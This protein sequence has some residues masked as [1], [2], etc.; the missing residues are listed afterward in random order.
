SL[1]MKR[2][3]NTINVSKIIF[4]VLVFSF[5][6]IIIKLGFVAMAPTTD[7]IDLT[8]F[9]ENRNT[10]EEILKANRGSIYS[11]DGE[12]LAQSI[13]SYTVIAYLSETRT[14]NPE[15]P[16]HVVDK[17]RTAR[18][19]AP[20]LGTTE[21]Y[22]LDRLNTEGR[23]QVELGTSG[24][25]ISTLLKN[26]I[27]E[28]GLPGISFIESQK[29]YYPMS[30]FAPYIIGYAQRDDTGTITGRMGIE[31][32]FDEELRG[33]DGKTIYQKDAYGYTMPN[34]TSI[35]DPAKPG[36]DIYLTLD[37][38]IQLFVENGIKEITE[39]NEMDWLTFSVMDAKTGAIVAT[40]SSPNFNLNTLAGIE[41]SWLN[42]LTT[43]AY[44][45][46]STMKI[47]SFLAAME[48]GVYDGQETYLS[49]NKNIDGSIINDFNGGKGWGVITYDEGFSYSS[50]VA[51]SNLADK[52]T[53]EKLY[54][55]Y[56]SLGFGKRTGMTLPN[57]ASGDIDFTYRTE[58]AT[59]SF[60][61]GITTTPIQNLQALSILTNEGVEIQPYI[62]EKIVNSATGE[63][64]YQH[65]RT[66]LG[67]KASK[68]NIDKMLTM[69]YD[70]VYSGKTDAKYYQANNITLVGKT[71]TAQIAGNNGYLSG[72]TDY[73]RSFAGVFPYEN[74][75]YIIY[76][77]V[78]KYNGKYK[79]F[80]GMVTKVVEEIAK[81]KNITEL[82]EKV[83]NNKIITI[84]NYI[85]TETILTEDRLKALNLNVIKL[86]NGKYIINQYPEKGKV[87]ISGDKIFLLTN[88]SSYK[89]PNII[90]WSSS[91]VQ[92]LCKLL[93]LNLKTSGY[94]RVKET[95]ILEGTDII[96]GMKIEVTFE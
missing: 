19:L 33:E 95:S 85:S 47:F 59:A 61:Q 50:N 56:A 80:A 27:E 5:F 36:E 4:V 37:S 43:Y 34:T 28:L 90:G 75:Q 52:I 69:M 92:T 9:V 64:T 42:P 31:A 15:N 21:E 93:G 81:Y 82:I 58:V 70:V 22:I 79:D 74:P 54:N 55:F 60:G 96:S 39:N 1:L 88:D 51:A 6:A 44:E 11:T 24:K 73:I 94:G 49:G 40:G 41:K 20:L 45:P 48:N 18:E 16:K 76:V 17:E 66:E 86:G 77:S 35:T 84:N 67:T 78:K 65:E 53:R 29:R 2:K 83:D 63:T 14:K 7:G 25:D 71:G 87:I 57:E 12:I 72:P 38:K 26:Q 32:Y 46:G 3:N 62:V 68:E 8:A 89:M 91:E 30:T 10:E 13:N 23:Y